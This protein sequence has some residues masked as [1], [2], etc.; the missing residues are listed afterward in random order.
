MEKANEQ[1]ALDNLQAF[2]K[3]ASAELDALGRN[4]LA[5]LPLY[6]G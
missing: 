3:K 2:T 5:A 1:W 6:E 4:A